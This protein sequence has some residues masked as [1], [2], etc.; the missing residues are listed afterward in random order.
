MIHEWQIVF[1]AGMAF[2]LSLRWVLSKIARIVH[3][4]WLALALALGS[5]ACATPHP[6]FIILHVAG[7]GASIGHAANQG[8][9]AIEAAASDEAD[10]DQSI[11]AQ[12]RRARAK[13]EADLA[14]YQAERCLR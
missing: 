2:G 12:Q 9:K 11:A 6:L 3:V 5:Q 14:A 13:V 8:K 10:E 7:A 1:L 4:P